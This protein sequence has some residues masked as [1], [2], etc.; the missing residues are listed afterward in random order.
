MVNE[1]DKNNAN[2][3][4]D[5]NNEKSAN[6]ANTANN[7][8]NVN[9]ANNTMTVTDDPKRVICYGWPLEKFPLGTSLATRASTVRSLSLGT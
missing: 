7:V 1:A 5:A 9:N 6:D 4:N 3:G 8:N 2:N